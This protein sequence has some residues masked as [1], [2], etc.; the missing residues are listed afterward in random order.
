MQIAD[1]ICDGILQGKWNEGE[2]IPSVRELAVSM[3]VNPHTILRSYEYLQTRDIITNKRGVGYS[4]SIMGKEKILSY[5]K[6]RFIETELPLFFSTLQLLNISIE[7]V[8]TLYDMQVTR[9]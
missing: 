6:E 7:E 4:V 9:N 5:R 1:Y 8:K 3:E 2:R